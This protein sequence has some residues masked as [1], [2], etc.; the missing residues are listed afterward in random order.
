[1]IKR[2]FII[3]LCFVSF[4]CLAGTNHNER[5][6]SL[7]KELKSIDDYSSAVKIENKIWKLWVTH[8]SEESLT[9]LL[10]KGSNY[11]SQNRLGDAYVVFTDIISKDRNWAEAWNKRATVLYLMGEYEKSQNDIDEVLNLEKRH[12]GALSGQGLVQTALKNYQKAIDSYIETHKIYPAMETPLIM[13][14]KLKLKIQ[15]ESI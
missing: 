7:F 6:D 13:I 1:M 9:D 4:S 2:L 8:P 3:L 12:F 5:L 10:A 11:M 14:E 15:K